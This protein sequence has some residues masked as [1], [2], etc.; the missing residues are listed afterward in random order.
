MPEAR[1][2]YAPPWPNEA[3]AGEEIEDLFRVGRLLALGGKELAGYLE[4]DGYQDLGHWL[5]AKCEKIIPIL[6]ETEG[7]LF[8][9]QMDEEKRKEAAWRQVVEEEKRKEAAKQQT[10]EVE[11]GG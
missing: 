7:E 4:D 10:V 2:E 11:A 9:L 8:R 5:W 1:V 3:F 6:L